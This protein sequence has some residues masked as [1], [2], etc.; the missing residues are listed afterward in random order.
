MDIYIEKIEQIIDYI[1]KHLDEKYTLEELAAQ[2]H[3]S[4]FHFHRI[5]QIYTGEA[6]GDYVRKR[7]LTSA[8][9]ALLNSHKKVIEIGLDFGFD[10]Q[11][12]FSRSFKKQFGL[13]PQHYRQTNV[14]NKTLFRVPITKDYLNHLGKG[15]VS[16]KP[17]YI[18]LKP[19]Y[20]IG[21]AA[22][23]ECQFL[24]KKI[25]EATLEYFQRKNEIKNLVSED[26][27][28][29]YL[30]VKS[31]DIQNYKLDTMMTHIVCSQVT[32]IEFVPEGMTALTIQGGKYAVFR[33]KGKNIFETNAYILNT[34]NGRNGYVFDEREDFIHYI[35][36]FRADVQEPLAD[37]Y[38][39]VK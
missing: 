20:F 27:Y 2:I 30:P 23:S 31:L 26:E 29:I 28:G 11:E 7:R 22:V 36:N 3:L 9:K 34:W 6:L 37:I 21:I 15:G 4:P 17:R 12:A 10:S 38:I 24:G 13:S 16:L 39:P 1:E 8:A 19:M 18:D 32:A 14:T 33:H 5:F 35:S 25:R